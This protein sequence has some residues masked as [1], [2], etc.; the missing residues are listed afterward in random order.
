LQV[1]DAATSA[2]LPFEETRLGR[3]LRGELVTSVS[4]DIRTRAF[5]GRELELNASAAPLREREPDG[6]IVGAVLVLRDLT[7]RNRLAREGEAAR[8]DELA[9]CKASQRLETYLATAAHDLRAPLTTIVGYIDLAERQ[10]ERL[11][12]TAQGERPELLR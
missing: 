5:D 7:E 11:A 10:A 4:E 3:V 12:A 2:P 1:R 8:A 9:A 6:Q